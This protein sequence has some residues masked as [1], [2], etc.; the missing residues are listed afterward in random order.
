MK[1]HAE[2]K[3]CAV[4]TPRLHL[5]RCQFIHSKN[6]RDRCYSCSTVSFRVNV[7]VCVCVRSFNSSSF[8]PLRLYLNLRLPS[9]F[10]I[11]HDLS[12]QNLSHYLFYLK[13]CFMCFCPLRLDSWRLMLFLIEARSFQQHSTDLMHSSFKSS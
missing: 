1:K 6:R 8:D 5:S 9:Y 13:R 11:K 7:N 10:Y 12:A 4:F 3:T 2:L